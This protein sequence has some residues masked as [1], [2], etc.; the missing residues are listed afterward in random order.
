MCGLNQGTVVKSDLKAITHRLLVVARGVEF[1]EVAGATGI[2]KERGREG[3][4]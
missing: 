4:N 2:G 1:E 3:G